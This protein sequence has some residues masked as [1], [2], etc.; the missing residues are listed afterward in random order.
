MRGFLSL[1]RV[2]HGSIGLRS[3]ESRRASGA[4]RQTSLGV[5]VDE[6]V[7]PSLVTSLISL[8][9]KHEG[10]R[11]RRYSEKRASSSAAGSL[12]SLELIDR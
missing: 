9:E 1:G 5:P 4:K 2:L 12:Y 3:G 11:E 8:I 10:D 6:C 7:L